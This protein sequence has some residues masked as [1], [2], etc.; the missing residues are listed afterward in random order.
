MAVSFDPMSLETEEALMLR[1]TASD[2]RVILRAHDVAVEQ[3]LGMLAEGM[4]PES[5]VRAH[6]GMGADD[7]RACLV[8]ARRLVYFGSPTTGVV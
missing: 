7:I 1:I 8:Y 5:I 2:G 6:A 3:V 4:T